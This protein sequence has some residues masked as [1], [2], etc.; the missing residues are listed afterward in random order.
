MS[1]DRRI[2]LNVQYVAPHNKQEGAARTATIVRGED[3]FGYYEAEG[4]PQS[5][6]D[7][8]RAEELL[9]ADRAMKES[10]QTK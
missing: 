7:V 6:L 10:F 2:G 1:D 5:A 9:A 4:R 8:E 3:R